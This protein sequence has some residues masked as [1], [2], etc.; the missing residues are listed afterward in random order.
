M[1]ST[2]LVNREEILKV[3]FSFLTFS[4]HSFIYLYEKLRDTMVEL[5]F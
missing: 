3:I 5:E 1:T 2:T 4:L